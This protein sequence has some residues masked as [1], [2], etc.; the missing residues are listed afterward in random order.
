[1]GELI[2]PPRAQFD[3]CLALARHAAVFRIKRRWGMQWFEEDALAIERHLAA[4][5]ESPRK[6]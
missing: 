5:I 4:P 1:M 3:Q 6:A 2:Q